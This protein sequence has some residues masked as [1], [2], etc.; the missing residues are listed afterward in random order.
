MHHFKAMMREANHLKKVKKLK[1]KREE[2]EGLEAYYQV[3]WL[4]LLS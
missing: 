3:E 2:M 1:V 4:I